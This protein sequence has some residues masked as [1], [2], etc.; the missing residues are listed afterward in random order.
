[1]AKL[2]KTKRVLLALAIFLASPALYLFLGC[3]GSSDV[4]STVT[5]PVIDPEGRAKVDALPDYRFP[6]EKSYLS[7]PEWYVVYTSQDFARFIAK[8]YPSGF[9]YFRSA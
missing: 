9:G 2:R 5:V 4:G 1:M 3:R 7:F 6:E 8:T